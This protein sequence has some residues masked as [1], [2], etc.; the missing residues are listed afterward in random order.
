MQEWQSLISCLLPQARAGRL[1]ELKAWP[2]AAQAL[3][4]RGPTGAKGF[5]LP[6]GRRGIWRGWRV[7][8]VTYAQV[9]PDW[10]NLGSVQSSQR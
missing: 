2:Q 8:T 5:D 3:T 4:F 6:E 7:A 10:T 9:G 1:P